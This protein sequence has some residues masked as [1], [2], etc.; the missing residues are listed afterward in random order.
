[1]LLALLA[2]SAG[3]SALYVTNPGTTDAVLRTEVLGG[4]SLQASVPLP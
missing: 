3:I 4:G 1:V 2:A